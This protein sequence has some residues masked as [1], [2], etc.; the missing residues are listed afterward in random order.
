MK[1]SV[2]YDSS[3]NGEIFIRGVFGPRTINHFLNIINQDIKRFNVA[4]KALSEEL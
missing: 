2:K 4:L 3:N 1:I